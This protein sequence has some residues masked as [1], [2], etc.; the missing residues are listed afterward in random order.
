[1]VLVAILVES[2]VRAQ[3]LRFWAYSK[4]QWLLICAMCLINYVS[5]NCLTIAMQNERSG[6]VTLIGYIGVVYAF[7]GDFFIFKEQFNWL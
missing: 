2:L 6:F 4:E 7:A 3:P 5:M 1:M